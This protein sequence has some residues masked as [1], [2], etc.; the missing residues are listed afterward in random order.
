MKMPGAGGAR[1]PWY[2]R[3]GFALVALGFLVL[4]PAT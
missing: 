3:I 2:G 1:N 4:A